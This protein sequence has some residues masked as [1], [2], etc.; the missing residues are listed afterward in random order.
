[1]WDVQLW[2]CGG[3]FWVDF[4]ELLAVG[5]L[6]LEVTFRLWTEAFLILDHYFLPLLAM[7]LTAEL[8]LFLPELWILLPEFAFDFL[9]ALDFVFGD[10]SF[11][12]LLDVGGVVAAELV[13]LLAGF[14]L[15][16]QEDLLGDSF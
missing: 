6:V 11:E 9:V 14:E 13:V 4:L 12:D 2:E 8:R 5:L 15:F 7:N 1:V 16:F 3:E 10:A